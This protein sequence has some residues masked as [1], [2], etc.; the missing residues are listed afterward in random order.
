[1]KIA[2]LGGTGRQG[3]GLAMRLALAGHE[4]R[5]G[6]RTLAK[7][8][9][10]V[11]EMHERLQARATLGAADNLGAA[12]WCELALLTVPHPH[13]LNTIERVSAQ[14][15]GKILV[16]VSVPLVSYRPAQVALPPAGSAAEAVQRCLGEHTN[17]VAAFKT[18]SAAVL[19]QLD[20]TLPS[21]E[22]VCGDDADARAVVMRLVS[23]LG[24]RALDAGAL[25]NARALELWT[26]LLIGLDQRYKKKAVGFTFNGL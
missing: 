18:T 5:V 20:K 4:V 7:A 15:E 2:V 19:Q 21:D 17:V 22:L 23:D 25:R 3:K 11:V 10:A 8:E 12:R 26:A 13:E 16:D 14:L 6:S 9:S 1:M 24:A